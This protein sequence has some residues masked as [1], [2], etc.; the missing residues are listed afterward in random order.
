MA[1]KKE[2]RWE[3][4][5]KKY[6]ACCSNWRIVNGVGYKITEKGIFVWCKN[7]PLKYAKWSKIKH[8]HS[9]PSSFDFELIWA[10]TDESQQ[11]KEGTEKY[12]EHNFNFKKWRLDLNWNYQLIVLQTAPLNSLI[13]TVGNIH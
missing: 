12:K 10:P 3:N 7:I 13:C 4:E 8:L 9:L 1:G 2:A 6:K 11:S 5:E